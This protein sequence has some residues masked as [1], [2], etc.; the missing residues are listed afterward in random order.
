M[1]DWGL[2]KLLRLHTD[3]HLGLDWRRD[4]LKVRN[5]LVSR[6]LFWLLCLRV[7][8]LVD[9]LTITVVKSF[10]LMLGPERINHTPL[11]R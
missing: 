10:I 11:D 1:N 8:L 5:E 6:L 4:R 3:D 2:R 7:T 9:R